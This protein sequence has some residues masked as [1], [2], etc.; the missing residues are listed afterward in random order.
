MCSS[1][2]HQIGQMN[3]VMKMGQ[4]VVLMSPGEHV[5]LLL[6]ACDLNILRFHS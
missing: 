2:Q 4:E 6:S 3:H 1:K 5:G